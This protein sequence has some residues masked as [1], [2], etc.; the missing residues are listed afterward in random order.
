LGCLHFDAAG[1]DFPVSS[2]NDNFHKIFESAGSTF[3]GALRSRNNDAGPCILL[4]SS[5]GPRLAR[6]ES[7]F[8]F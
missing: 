1:T 6:S 3:Q 8:L 4:S 5:C 2:V 7:L